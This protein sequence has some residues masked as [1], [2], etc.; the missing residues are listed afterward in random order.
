MFQMVEKIKL[1]LNS[2]MN[3]FTISILLGVIAEFQQATINSTKP[4]FKRNTKSF[5]NT[6]YE[7]YREMFKS[8]FPLKDST[9]RYNENE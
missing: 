3:F 2:K 7:Q 5:I 1:T 8:K 6:D 4:Y 9:K